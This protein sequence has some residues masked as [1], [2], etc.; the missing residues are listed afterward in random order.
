MVSP[1]Y[2]IF[3]PRTLRTSCS[4]F[5]HPARAYSC[6]HA[7]LCRVGATSMPPDPSP[8]GIRISPH[9]NISHF[10]SGQYLTPFTRT[11]LLRGTHSIRAAKRDTI[12]Y[13][14]LFYQTPS[15]PAGTWIRDFPVPRGSAQGTPFGCRRAASR[16]KYH[17]QNSSGHGHSRCKRYCTLKDFPL[18]HKRHRVPVQAHGICKDIPADFSF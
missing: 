1:Y 2:S 16:R 7:S 11:G 8:G 14:V 17:C 6:K 15:L 13:A 5:L 3:A 10:F 12:P 18:G 9:S 4:V